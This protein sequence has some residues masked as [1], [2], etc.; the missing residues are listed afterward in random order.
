MPRKQ[1]SSKLK[2]SEADVQQAVVL[3]LELDGWRA[4]R[5]DPVSDRSRGK[6]FG[7]VGMPDYLFIRYEFAHYCVNELPRGFL[8]AKSQ[9]AQ[10]IWVEFKAPGKTLKP[11]QTAWHSK[12][13]ARGARIFI[14]DDAVRF[15]ETYKT[16]GLMRHQILS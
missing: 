4:I 3:M 5:T 8:I 10:V 13:G 2:V 7:E 16:S 11:H 15:R 14:V 6:G 1:Q 9:W 12:E